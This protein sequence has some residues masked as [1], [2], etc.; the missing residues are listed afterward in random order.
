MSAMTLYHHRN[1]IKYEIMNLLRAIS[2]EDH[3]SDLAAEARCVPQ[4]CVDSSY[5]ALG[6]VPIPMY[7]LVLEVRKRKYD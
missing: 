6:F 1:M 3:E 7:H 2:R 5:T 4:N